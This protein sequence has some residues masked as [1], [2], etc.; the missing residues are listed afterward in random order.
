MGRQMKLPQRLVVREAASRQ[1]D[2]A[3][4]PHAAL[5]VRPAEH[6][7]V[8][9]PGI[10]GQR[11]RDGV[12]R[13]PGVTVA[14][15]HLAGEHRAHGAVHVA[16]RMLD[17]HRLATLQRRLRR[18]DQL[19]VQRLVEVMVLFLAVV[20]RHA[21]LRHRLIQHAAEI[22]ALGFPV[23]DRSAGIQLVH[24]PD[25]FVE[26]PEA[27]LRHD[28]PD[29]FEGVEPGEDLGGGLG[30]VE[31]LVQQVEAGAGQTGDFAVS[32]VHSL[33]WFTVS[34]FHRGNI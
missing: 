21:R 11:D 7:A 23:L 18:D 5:A 15:R 13:Q 30:A 4:R 10:A 17:A 32:G 31:G 1:H 34:V 20:D 9:A 14:L 33:G 26:G 16:D 8:N 28:F 29:F 22:D 3:L 25:H 6:D 24:P 2:A 27:K 19:L 12:F